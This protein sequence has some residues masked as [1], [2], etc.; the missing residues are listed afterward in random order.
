[1]RSPVMVH[2]I[3]AFAIAVQVKDVHPVPKKDTRELEP[4]TRP[5]LELAPFKDIKNVTV[6]EYNVKA[7]DKT[8]YTIRVYR[9]TYPGNIDTERERWMK[10]FTE[11][12][13]WRIRSK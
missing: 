9:F 7:K 6:S 4:S 10:M 1:M 5:F 3:F 2:L 13:G 8:A 11:A 12:D